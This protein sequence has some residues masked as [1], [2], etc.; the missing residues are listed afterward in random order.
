MEGQICLRD[1]NNMT[2]MKRHIWLDLAKH[3]GNNLAKIKDII[4]NQIKIRTKTKTMIN[5]KTTEDI[6]TTLTMLGEVEASTNNNNNNKS[7]YIFS[8]LHF[9]LLLR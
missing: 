6:I 9:L 8:A 7:N 2:R 4:L 1:R 3:S 5:S